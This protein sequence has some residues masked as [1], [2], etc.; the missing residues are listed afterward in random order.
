[1]GFKMEKCRLEFK[2]SPCI[3]VCSVRKPLENT[4]FET[5]KG[6]SEIC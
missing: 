6:V 1:M 4:L 2:T 3:G 5:E